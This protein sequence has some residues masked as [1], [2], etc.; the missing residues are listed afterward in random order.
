[1]GII[2]RTNLLFFLVWLSLPSFVMAQSM[3]SISLKEAI[4]FAQGHS[5]PIKA[6]KERLQEAAYQRDKARGALLPSL[7]LVA[8][9]E[10]MGLNANLNLFRGFQDS[11]AEDVANLAW[12]K[13]RLVL[14]DLRWKNRLAVEEV[15]H[16]YLSRQALSANKKFEISLNSKH[17]DIVRQSRARG[18]ASDVDLQLFEL[19]DAKLRSELLALRN[20]QEDLRSEF[21]NLLGAEVGSHITP[22]GELQHQHLRTDLSQSL[23]SLSETSYAIKLAALDVR[24]SKTQADKAQSEWLPQVDLDVSV[25]AP[26]ASE[27][28]QGIEPRVLL[29]AKLPLFSGGQWQAEK[30]AKLSAASAQSWDFK[31]LIHTSIN[32]V[33]SRFRNLKIN[34]ERADLEK[35]NTQY[36]QRYYDGILVEYRRGY[37]SAFDLIEALDQWMEAKN[38]QVELEQEFILGRI[39]LER[40]LG[41]SVV[42]EVV[43]A[44]KNAEK[45]PGP[46]SGI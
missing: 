3:Q 22:V 18:L 31:Q 43:N 35:Y 44:E 2:T 17:L 6:A 13:A 19:K 8:S 42:I 39:A 46:R 10:S 5:F 14:E 9:S 29:S 7:Q 30:R 27:Q 38:R 33:E 11:Y 4:E 34:Q 24:I 45:T 40:L 25:V 15:F 26:S 36:A 41:Q 28:G 37:K 32:E 16:T 1:M 12:E 21:K 23:N 20:S